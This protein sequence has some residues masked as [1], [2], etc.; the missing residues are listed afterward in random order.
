[1]QN[2]NRAAHLKA[3]TILKLLQ[4]SW[5]SAAGVSQLPVPPWYWQVAVLDVMNH[6][7]VRTTSGARHEQQQQKPSR[8]PLSSAASQ[9]GGTISVIV[10]YAF[11]LMACP[12]HS[13]GDDPVLLL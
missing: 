13:K 9:E 1:M 7:G 3:L 5:P 10:W 12:R 4:V 6:A 2:S 8:T 11:R